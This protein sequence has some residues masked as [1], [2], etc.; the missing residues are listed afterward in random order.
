MQHK[1]KFQLVEICGDIFK[2]TPKYFALA[3]CVS[4]DLRMGRGI[5]VRFRQLF[6]KVDELARQ[7][8]LPGGCAHIVVNGRCI[9]YLVTKQRCFHTPKYLHLRMS[10]QKMRDTVEEYGIDSVA[11]PRIGSGL[12][13]LKWNLVRAIIEDVFRDSPVLIHVYYLK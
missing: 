10:L 13:G 5:A 4:A 12:D 3:H 2:A 7:K 8:Q 1:P 11:M 9:F 6:G